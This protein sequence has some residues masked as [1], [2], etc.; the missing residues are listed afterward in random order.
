MRLFP[1]QR[2]I[3]WLSYL[4]LLYDGKGPVP[5]PPFHS[6]FLRSDSLSVKSHQNVV[7]DQLYVFHGFSVMLMAST[8]LQGMLML[9]YIKLFFIKHAVLF[10]FVYKF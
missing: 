2:S 1:A 10:D 8:R 4:C 5:R 7:N 3:I 9:I 6:Q